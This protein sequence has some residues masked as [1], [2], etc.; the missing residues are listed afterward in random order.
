MHVTVRFFLH[1]FMLGPPLPTGLLQASHPRK[2]R[3][4]LPPVG[5]LQAL[6]LISPVIDDYSKPRRRWKR[7]ALRESETRGITD[8][9]SFYLFRRALGSRLREAKQFAQGLRGLP[10]RGPFP[11]GQQRLRSNAP[12]RWWTLCA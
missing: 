1:L 2:G 3:K 12:S 11:C 10:G 5:V 9:R 6:P 4:G 8:G 7:W